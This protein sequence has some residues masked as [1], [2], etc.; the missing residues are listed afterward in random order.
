[1][2]RCSPFI[3]GVGCYGSG[4]G[5]GGGATLTI[6]V[7]LDAAL[8][9]PYVSGVDF[10]DDIWIHINTGLTSPTEYRFLIFDNGLD[11][12]HVVQAGDTLQWNVRT[13]TDILIYAE[14]V[15][16]SSAACAL[17][18]FDVHVDADAEANAYIAAHN[19]LSGMVMGAH[20]QLVVQGMYQRLKGTGTTFG[21]N[22]WTIFKNSGTRI[23]GYT[24]VDDSTVNVAAYGLDMIQLALQTFH[25]YAPSDYTVNGLIG[26]VGKY[27]KTG[28]YTTNFGLNNIGGDVYRRTTGN[29]FEMSFGTMTSN[30]WGSATDGY[31][32]WPRYS[33]SIY[34]HANSGWVGG[35]GSNGIGHTAMQRTS[36]SN[37]S[38][39]KDGIL[40][41]NLN[42]VS[43]AQSA[44][45]IYG[46]ATNSSVGAIYNDP[47]EHAWLCPARPMLTANE[48]S[49]YYEVVKYYQENIITG[50]RHVV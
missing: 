49:D 41:A 50:G 27:T 15:N 8:T 13:F 9:I 48:M 40:L 47:A 18:S 12:T 22:L 26:G 20:Q 31:T 23:F 34:T 28:M 17:T 35:L 37:I 4:G 43:V 1:M 6:E 14:A 29:G 42:K 24:P 16:G 2:S 11:G 38:I 25:G 46:H 44:L 39:Y 30:Y 33:G 32:L 3:F 7:Y 21:S 5:G 10:Q 45:E 36:N 19:A